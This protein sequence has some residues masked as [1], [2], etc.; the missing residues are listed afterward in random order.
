MAENGG[1]VKENSGG[2]INVKIHLSLLRGV[3]INV[4]ASL[5]STVGRFCDVHMTVGRYSQEGVGMGMRTDARVTLEK[6]WTY[7]HSQRREYIVRVGWKKDKPPKTFGVA[8]I[9]GAEGD[10]YG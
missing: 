9:D 6:S 5:A 4:V 8:G 1:L 2:F 3:K 10:W 7:I